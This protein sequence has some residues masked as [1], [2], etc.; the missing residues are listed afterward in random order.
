M[1]IQVSPKLIEKASRLFNATLKEV[2][3][4]LLQNSRR[5]GAS[6]IN[7]TAMER[8]GQ[9]WIVIADDGCGF[10]DEATILLGESGWDDGTVCREDPAG[11]GV[12]ALANRGAIVE[13]S[14]WRVE[15]TE[16]HFCGKEDVVIE[17]SEVVTGTRVLFPLSKSEIF[18][19]LLPVVK[20]CVLFYPFPVYFEGNEI[21]RQEFLQGAVYRQMWHGLEIGVKLGYHKNMINF[22]GLVIEQRLAIVDQKKITAWGLS[23]ETFSV[24]INVVDASDLKLVLPARKEAVQNE[25]FRELQKE[26]YRV[27]YRY[28]N[29]LT[30]HNLSYQDWVHARSLGVVLPEAEKQLVIYQP[31]APAIDRF[32]DGTPEMQKV[33]EKAL[34]FA[35]DCSLPQAQLFCRGFRKTE[36][37]YTLC[38]SENIY[39]GYQWYDALPVISKFSISLE[40][41]GK[42]VELAAAS[43]LLGDKRAEAIWIEGVIVQP[44][45]A[46][47]TIRLRTDV[48]FLDDDRNYWGELSGV[49]VFVTQDSQIE[50]REL[51]DILKD[52]YFYVSDDVDAD[53]S[54]T[55]EADFE[56]EAREKA[57][58]VL[59]S[60]EAALEERIKM[61]A[62][63]DL[64]WLV[65]LNKR[66]DLSIDHQGTITLEWH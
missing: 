18:Q 51:A 7:I 49:T 48:A 5:A 23:Y 53:S 11:M 54:E 10:R 21:E 14:G 63:R 56:E 36:L 66:L 30:S 58:S 38:K 45:K 8:D 57:A 61:V 19:G 3:N 32:D 47:K 1:K 6:R 44:N 24:F 52:C 22:Y 35:A 34:V 59:L 31:G 12:F 62:E 28:I 4:E 43:N 50:V 39:E 41:D 65:P 46:T 15:L 29:T 55:Q 60:K 64:R 37:N 42:N 13:S 40:F 2:L 20:K 26:S 17:N 16:A 27:I 9:Q 25:F 33:D